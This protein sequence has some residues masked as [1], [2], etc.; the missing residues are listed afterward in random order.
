L[1]ALR[2]VEDPL[3]RT[4][5]TYTAANLLA[6]RGDY[7]E[8]QSFLDLF[9]DDVREYSLEFAVPFV[10]WTF[11]F[12]SLGLRRFGE[13]DRHLQLL[14]DT[15]ERQHLWSHKLNARIL[16][17]RLL[18]QTG[19]HEKAL[20][21]VRNDDDLPLIRSW[22]AEYVATRALVL[23]RLGEYEAAEKA[24]AA[25]AEISNEAQVRVLVSASRAVA[26]ASQGD[27]SEVRKFLALAS[28]L[29]VWDTVIC[30]LRCSPELADIVAQDET[31]RP[32]L[33]SLYERSNDHALARRAGFRT[34]STRAPHE[35]LSPREHEVLGLMARGLRN[36]E[37]ASALFIAESTAKV[38]VRHILDKLGVHTRAEAVA[39]FE[40][41]QNPP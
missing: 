21:F 41:L 17:A 12:I 23:A 3:A 8:A 40:R 18:L 6:Q 7:R 34:R 11:A 35:I 28:E 29:A 5:F 2:Q 38:H 37:I 4:S 1:H 25:A 24:A 31:L 10:A 19:E 15:A 39:R 16:R 26:M 33:R 9:A 30:A 36:R 20:D 32:I 14:E 13:A 22:R 27:I